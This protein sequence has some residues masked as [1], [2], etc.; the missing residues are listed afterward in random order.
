MTLSDFVMVALGE[1]ILA[2]TFALGIGV[3]ISLARKDSSHGNRNE[4][5]EAWHLGHGHHVQPRNA[6]GSR[7]LVI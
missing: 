3:G 1:V 4:G 2:A 5:S 7:Y 6:I